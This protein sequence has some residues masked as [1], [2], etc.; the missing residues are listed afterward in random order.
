M[1][2]LLSDTTITMLGSVLALVAG[3]V[4]RAIFKDKQ[5]KANALFQTAVDVAYNVVNDIAKRTDSKID[6]KVALGLQVLRD[7]Y[8]LHNKDV[9]DLDIEKAKMLF[10]A[11]HGAE[12]K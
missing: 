2:N 7:F 12:Q 1:T 4:V 10:Q 8:A 11:M 3:A 6:D 5:D 9:S